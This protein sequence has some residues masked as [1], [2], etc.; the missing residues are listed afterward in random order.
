MADLVLERFQTGREQDRDHDMRDLIDL[1]RQLEEIITGLEAR[2]K[3]L[4]DA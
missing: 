2:I 1:A 3:A 4:E